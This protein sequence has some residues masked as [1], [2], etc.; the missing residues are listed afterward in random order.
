VNFFALSIIAL[1]S[2]FVALG[3]CAERLKIFL[4]IF[5]GIS[6]NVVARRRTSLDVRRTRTAINSIGILFNKRFLRVSRFYKPPRCNRR[7]HPI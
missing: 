5:C 6:V 3:F 4:I 1:W 2:S 7:D